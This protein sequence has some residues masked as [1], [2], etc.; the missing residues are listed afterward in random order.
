MG[1]LN[2]DL[3]DKRKKG[4]LCAEPE[5]AMRQRLTRTLG[6]R[7]VVIQF[8]KRGHEFIP[9]RGFPESPLRLAPAPTGSTP[10]AG[11]HSLPGRPGKEESHRA[12]YNLKGRKIGRDV[13]DNDNTHQSFLWLFPYGA[14]TSTTDSNTR[15]PAASWA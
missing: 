6:R 15:C 9:K 13:R 8:C 5:H 3:P 7:R 12:L 2:N 1:T 11:G 10:A 4:C 14:L